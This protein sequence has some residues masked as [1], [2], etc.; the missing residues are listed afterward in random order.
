M[1]VIL[2]VVIYA[3]CLMI[4]SIAMYLSDIF[5]W[6]FLNILC[7]CIFTDFVLNCCLCSHFLFVQFSYEIEFYN[8]ADSYILLCHIDNINIR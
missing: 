5:E 6:R 2:Y 3:S 4:V 1:R 7:F 8:I